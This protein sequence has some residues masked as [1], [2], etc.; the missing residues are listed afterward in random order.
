MLRR[1]SSRRCVSQL[2]QPISL[3]V[4]VNWQCVLSQI[5]LRC[6]TVPQCDFHC[7]LT[8]SVFV[9]L[10][11]PW[12]WE[13]LIPLV[14]PWLPSCPSPSLS[15]FQVIHTCMNS[16][17]SRL[18]F[19]L[20][21][22]DHPDTL[23]VGLIWLFQVLRGLKAIMPSLLMYAHPVYRQPRNNWSSLDSFFV[24]S[25]GH[26]FTLHPFHII[27][28]VSAILS[29]SSVTFCALLRYNPCKLSNLWCNYCV[30]NVVT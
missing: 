12:S 11:F 9:F 3:L 8:I 18:I 29:I 5:S 6:A 25:S 10:P 2:W 20:S 7:W 4:S 16:E 26:P 28:T 13:R 23:T 19:F 1:Q 21:I 22:P 17:Y 27:Q 15:K 24:S 30:L 14:R